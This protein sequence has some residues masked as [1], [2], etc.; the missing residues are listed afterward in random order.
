[1]SIPEDA[2]LLLIVA[3]GVG[4]FEPLG[5]AVVRSIDRYLE[6]GGGVAILLPA[7]GISGL[8]DLMARA[9]IS[10][11]PGLIAEEIPLEQGFV[12]PAFVA[13]GRDVNPDHPA[14]ASFGLQIM[15]ARFSPARALQ[16]SGD[17]EALLYTGPGAWIERDG[18]MA[19]RDPA[20]SPG[21]RI[22]AA[23]SDVGSGRLVVAASWT[24]VLTEFWRGDSRRF[25]L[26]C[27]GWAAGD[28]LPLGAGREP[29]SRKV[30][31]SPQFRNSFFWTA[32]FV[33]PSCAFIGGLLVAAVRRRKA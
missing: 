19:R 32:I 18:Q 2:D 31:L 5:A 27:F 21:P 26:S 16:V 11:S 14:T 6:S 13:V 15:D 25:L 28:S 1:M 17:A 3:G 33:L 23:A 4:G 12:R 20:E 22:V 8:E 9:G 10:V 7:T 30:E 24:P 29:V